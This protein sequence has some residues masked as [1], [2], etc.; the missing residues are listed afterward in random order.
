MLGNVGW[1]R[2]DID[3]AAE[4][5]ACKFTDPV[6]PMRDYG[7]FLKYLSVLM[8]SFCN[9]WDRMQVRNA[10]LQVR[11]SVKTILKILLSYLRFHR[12]FSSQPC[13]VYNPTLP[14]LTNP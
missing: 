8:G 11:A 6:D 7:S 13:G 4:I 2:E 12:D 3:T 14:P 1:C 5:N 10:A 9:V